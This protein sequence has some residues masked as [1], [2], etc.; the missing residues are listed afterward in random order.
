[1]FYNESL[2]SAL[3]Y[4]IAAECRK[5]TKFLRFSS[6][7]PP[8]TMIDTTVRGFLGKISTCHSMPFHLRR[9]TSQRRGYGVLRYPE[10]GHGVTGGART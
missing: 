1:M 3:T 4:V 5:V 8:P 10:R 6:S 7:A 9:A 2:N